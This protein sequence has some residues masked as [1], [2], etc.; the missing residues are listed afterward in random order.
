LVHGNDIIVL[1]TYSKFCGGGTTI[2]LTNKYNLPVTLVNAIANDDYDVRQ[3]DPSI[4]SVTTL[5]TPP[6]IRQLRIRHYS[7]LNSDVSDNIW[8][9]LGS[10]VHAMLE[11]I[12]HP[13]YTIEKRISKKIGH[14]TLTGKC[15]LYSEKEKILK[16]YKIT[17]VWSVINSPNGKLEWIQQLNTYAFLLSL[18]GIEIDTLKIV[19]IL[20]DWNKHKSIQHGYP[21]TACKVINLPLWEKNEQRKFV[22]EKLDLHYKANGMDI[23]DIPICTSEE[24]WATNDEWACHKGTNKR[25]LRVFKFEQEAIEYKKEYEEK[26]PNDKVRI[27]E[28]KGEDKRCKSYCDVSEFCPY[29]KSI[30]NQKLGE[31]NYDDKG[32]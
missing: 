13:D 3:D 20:R 14:L 16:D 27:E 22:A 30:N 29:W 15:D 2:R 26:N 24:R 23:K 11:R 31:E 25:A 8:Q 1:K 10:C 5:I 6:L 12:D 18:N 4:I 7:E 21:D 17:S 9:L 28:R 32:K 19:A